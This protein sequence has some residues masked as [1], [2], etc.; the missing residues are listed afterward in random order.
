LITSRCTLEKF[1]EKEGKSISIKKA[2]KLFGDFVWDGEIGVK[3]NLN[4]I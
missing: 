4:P 1:Y 3:V 2:K